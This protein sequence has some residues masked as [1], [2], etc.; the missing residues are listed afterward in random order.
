MA[1]TGRPVSSAVA[2]AG[3]PMAIQKATLEQPVVCAPH[4]QHCHCVSRIHLP[5]HV[6][7][8]EASGLFR[9]VVPGGSFKFWLYGLPS[10]Q[11]P[12]KYEQ[13]NNSSSRAR[14]GAPFGILSRMPEAS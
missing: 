10:F 7:M 9:I 4:L 5:F 1:V 6:R 12:G 11:S 13:E 14:L 2:L 3:V 8:N